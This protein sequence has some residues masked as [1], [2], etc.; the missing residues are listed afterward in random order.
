L[1]DADRFDALRARHLSGDTDA[2][3]RAEW[4]SS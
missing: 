2:Q 1:R 4:E 3:V